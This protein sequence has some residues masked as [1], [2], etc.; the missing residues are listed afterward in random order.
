MVVGGDG[1]DD[2]ATRWLSKVKI[3][4][5]KMVVVADGDDKKMMFLS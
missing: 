3:E 4:T 2:N 5:G 1:D